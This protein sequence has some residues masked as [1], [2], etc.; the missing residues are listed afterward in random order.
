MAE[1]QP[2]LGVGLIVESAEEEGVVLV[3]KRAGS[4]AA[5]QF[6]IV[7]GKI[8]CGETF[9]AA[10]TRELYEETNLEVDEKAWRVITVINNLNLYVSE[11]VHSVSVI[12]HTTTFSGIQKNKEPHKN[13]SLVWLPWHAV[14]E[15]HFEPSKFGLYCHFEQTGLGYCSEEQK[16]SIQESL[17]S[18]SLIYGAGS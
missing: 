13:T 9:E 2:I 10:A 12:L 16:E 8:D 14:P 11:G 3:G 5:G 1:S 15:P 7:G 18:R 17:K 4:H 6:S